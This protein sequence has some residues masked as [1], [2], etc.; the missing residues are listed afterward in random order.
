MFQT[1]MSSF[2]L[3]NTN[4]AIVK[5]VKGIVQPKWKCYANLLICWML[6]IQDVGDLVSIYFFTPTVAV[7]QSFNGSQWYPQPQATA[8]REKKTYRDKNPV[9]TSSP[10]WYIEVLRHET[11]GLCKKLNIIYVNRYKCCS[12]SYRDRLFQVLRPQWPQRNSAYTLWHTHIHQ[13]I[14]FFVLRRRKKFLQV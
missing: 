4:L 12:V 14:Y 10:W 7:C 1:W 8:L 11:I 5:N 9:K 2:L 13:N 6:G 3:L